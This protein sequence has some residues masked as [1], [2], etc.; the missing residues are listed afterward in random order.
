MGISGSERRRIRRDERREA[1]NLVRRVVQPL[2]KLPV[3]NLLDEEALELIHQASMKILGEIGIDFYN[4]EAIDILREHGAEVKG[5]TVFF[6]QHLVEEYLSKAPR[7][8]TQRA[9]NP[10]NDVLIGGDAMCFAPIYGPPFVQDRDRGRRSATLIDFQNFVKLSYLSPYIHHSGGTVVEPTDEPVSTR[11][12][13]MLF[14]HIK[15]S[16]KAFMGS[17]ISAENAADCVAMVEILFGEEEIRQAPA[18]LSLINISSPRRLDERMLETL[19]V[20]A[21]AKQGLIITPFIL[22][23]AMAPASIAGTLAQQNAEAV[24]GIVYAQMVSAGTLV[25]YGSFLTNVDLKSGAPVFG[26][27]ESQLGLFVSAQMARRYGLPF[28]SGGM[29]ASSKLPDAQAAYE[30]V[31]TM[32]PAILAKVNFILHAAGWLENGMVAD[33]EK[34]VMD[35]EVLGMFHKFLG[36]VD[37]SEDAFAMESIQSVPPGGHHL[38][39][40]H[41]MRHFRTAF[42]R[43]ELFDYNSFDQWREEGSKDVVRKANEKLKAQLADYAT[44]ELDPAIEEALL[45][46]ISRR[47]IELRE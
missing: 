36:G 22:S 46:F 26:S 18:L 21:R 13:D 30:S 44:P 34:F 16:D 3:Y 33:Y 24:A 41:T 1:Q 12:L 32:L 2:H 17:V 35:C 47:K 20:Y 5:E 14:S 28:R 42:Y 9:R 31:M 19:T 4:Q 8:F 25:V 11:H 10:E 29:F 38:G 37:L 23:G 43:A 27:P 15:Y 40:D 39:T 7:Q 6:D 45:D